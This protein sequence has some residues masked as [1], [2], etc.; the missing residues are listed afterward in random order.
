MPQKKK[1]TG[2]KN[3]K[4]LGGSAG[5]SG[6]I[7]NSNSTAQCVRCHAIEPGTGGAVGPALDKIGSRLKRETLLEALINPSAK[8]RGFGQVIVT[9]KDGNEVMGTLML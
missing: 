9:L 6:R 4:Y 5:K 1:T 7:F 3:S 8:I 2:L